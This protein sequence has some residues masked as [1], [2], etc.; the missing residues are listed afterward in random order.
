MSERN[1]RRR[2]DVVLVLPAAA[3]SAGAALVTAQAP[4]V[5][6][7]VG[8]A[9]FLMLLP[10]I[11]LFAVFS[12]SALFERGT[13]EIVGLTFRFEELVLVPMVVRAYLLT[14]PRF[15]IR[16]QRAEWFLLGFIAMQFVSTILFAPSQRQSLLGAALLTFGAITYYTIVAATSTAR[17]LI[18]SVRVLLALLAFNALAGI[19]GVALRPIL[20]TPFGK[21]KADP[22]PAAIGLAWEPNL[23][24]SS[25][26]A[27]AMIFLALWREHNPVV[28]RRVALLGFWTN[29]LGMLLSLARGAWIGFVVVFALF[30]LLPRRGIRRRG[31]IER[32]GMAI[33]V[34]TIVIVGLGLIAQVSPQ[35]GNPLTALGPQSEEILNFETGTGRARSEE[36]RIAL[37]QF[38]SSPLLGLGTNS[39]GQRNPGIKKDPYL[40][41]LYIRTLYDTGIVGTAFLVAFLLAVLFPSR[42]LLTSPVPL[43]PVAR[44]LTFGWLILAVAYSATDSMLLIWPWISLALVRASRIL[45]DRQLAEAEVAAPTQPA[46]TA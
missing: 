46:T 25:C 6:A 14:S 15:R 10:W 4:L 42:R 2:D 16:W 18:Q 21:G 40:G 35:G 33:I 7:G 23:F 1:G 45:A 36:W 41:N 24:G 12:T 20:G 30:L 26:A 27:G 9:T 38:R 3:G 29:F 8:L 39:Y 22:V 5:G 19:V 11:L 17:R 43:A 44:A 28:S 31:G 37:G 32:I 34:G 13:F